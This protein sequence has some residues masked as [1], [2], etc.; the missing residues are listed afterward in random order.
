MV[1]TT[2]QYDNIIL[3][4]IVASAQPQRDQTL[5][6]EART[7]EAETEARTLEAEATQFSLRGLEAEAKP[8]GLKS[9]PNIV[10]FAKH[11]FTY[12]I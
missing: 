1:N 7:L 3:I 9:L 11:I 5:K 12:C 8:Q 10:E 4:I 2:I 6:A